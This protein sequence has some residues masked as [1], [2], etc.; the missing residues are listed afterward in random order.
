MFSDIVLIG[1]IGAGKTTVGRLLAEKLGLPQVSLDALCYDYYREIGWNGQEALRIY[2]QQGAE[3]FNEYTSRFEPH[4]VERVLSEHPHSVI[5]MGGVQTVHENETRFTR[6]QKALAS[7]TNVV[8]LLPCSDQ[9]E[10]V[11]ILKTRNSHQSAQYLQRLEHLARL[12]CNHA[13]AKFIVYTEGK[14]PE[15]VRDEILERTQYARHDRR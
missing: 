13:L 4:G 2:E 11:R 14:S 7:Y 3:A 12:P 10:S 5:D 9:D 15:Q 1:P 6:V 8:L